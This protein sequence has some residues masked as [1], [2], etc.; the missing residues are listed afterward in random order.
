[1]ISAAVASL[2]TLAAATPL[3]RLESYGTSSGAF[4]QGYLDSGLSATA[5]ASGS[6]V[7]GAESDGSVLVG[8]SELDDSIR[9]S[10]FARNWLRV[11]SHAGASS[12]E[13]L[14]A[15]FGA[16]SERGMGSSDDLEEVDR[17]Q[18][19]VD[20]IVRRFLR[21]EAD[22]GRVW[23]GPR[24]QGGGSGSSGGDL[25]LNLVR[26]V[27]VY[28][29]DEE[30]ALNA[31]NHTTEM[32]EYLLSM[33]AVDQANNFDLLVT[34]SGSRSASSS[35]KKNAAG[36]S[37]TLSPEDLERI[38]R[39]NKDTNV[40]SLMDFVSKLLIDVRILFFFGLSVLAISLLTML[41]SRWAKT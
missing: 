38:A 4:G 21:Q 36:P 18:I 6:A 17:E 33:T 9:N 20:G 23:T 40:A 22:K 7:L 30:L 32:R 15:S 10:S 35:G 1:M 19:T 37:S 41:V 2:A 13:W 8:A 34:G 14:L 39:D 11:T 24:G 31:L 12:E 27:L 26:E 5:G 16:P 3:E 29:M 25:G 28:R